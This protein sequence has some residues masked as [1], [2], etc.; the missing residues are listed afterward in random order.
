MQF[1]EKLTIYNGDKYRNAF[2][3]PVDQDSCKQL[4]KDKWNACHPTG[5]PKVSHPVCTI[6]M[7]ENELV[8]LYNAHM[9]CRN[10]R[11]I[12]NSSKCHSSQ[13]NG[14]K[15]AQRIQLTE[16]NR[17]MTFLR[18]K[19]ADKKKNQEQRIRIQKEQQLQQERELQE[20]QLQQERDRL[21]QIQLYEKEQTLNK[22]QEQEQ[23]Q[24]NPLDQDEIEKQKALR[25][26]QRILVKQKKKYVFWASFGFY[27]LFFISFVLLFM[28]VYYIL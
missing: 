24:E 6:H 1:V 12:E 5:D 18:E 11:A 15:I 21:E 19:I 10:F 9:T 28:F 14:H 4:R 17:C 25:K 3:D 16:A 2:K 22:E 13:D 26:Q 7:D 20:Q 8:Q 23:D 27:L